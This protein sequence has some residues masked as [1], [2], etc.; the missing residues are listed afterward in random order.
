M[1]CAVAVNIFWGSVFRFR[2]FKVSDGAGGILIAT[3]G[4]GLGLGDCEYVY[5]R[6]T[7]NEEKEETKKTQLSFPLAGESLGLLEFSCS[8]Y[9]RT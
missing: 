6:T 5:P 1:I 2:G 7:G 8:Y 3:R 4:D 9:M